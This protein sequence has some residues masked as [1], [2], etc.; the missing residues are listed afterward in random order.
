[1]PSDYTAVGAEIKMPQYFTRQA[2]NYCFELKTIAKRPLKTQK[3][4]YLYGVD[5]ILRPAFDS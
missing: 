4:P 3:S 1:M 2:E 5:R